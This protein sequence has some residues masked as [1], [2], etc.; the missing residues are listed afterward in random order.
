[1]EIKE[2]R[3]RQL[4]LHFLE[5]AK[6]KSNLIGFLIRVPLKKE[7][8][9]KV[10]V[11]SE[12][13]AEGAGAYAS[14]RE[15]AVAMEDCYGGIFDVSLLKKGEEQILFFYLEVV[16]C[17]EDLLEKAFVF[18][19]KIVEAPL[20][21]D[22][23][24]TEK[25]LQHS[26]EKVQKK[27]QRKKDDKKE[28]AK[29]RCLEELYEGKGFGVSG[30]GYEKDLDKINLEKLEK[31]CKKMYLESPMELL[32]LGEKDQLEDVKGYRKRFAIGGQTMCRRQ[33]EFV[34]FYIEK[35]E[36]CVEM[37]NVSQGRLSMAFQTGVSPKTNEFVTLL[38][39]NELLGGSSNSLLFQGL[40]EKQGL[41]YDISSYVYRFTGILMVQG[42]L[43]DKDYEKAKEEILTLLTD[44]TEEPVSKEKR[45]EAKKSL[46]RYFDSLQ[47]S[48][49]G[50][51]NFYLD[52]YLLGE[53][54]TIADWKK[55]I[56]QVSSR[57]IM[58]LA[59]QI[60][61]GLSYFLKRDGEKNEQK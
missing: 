56:R 9:T 45:V 14:T 4:Q 30:D 6:F 22:G 23:F 26:K 41:C 40:R 29:E 37:A 42:G 60:R 35:G 10:A 15:V 50:K 18:L 38:V 36:E 27:L 43:Q 19:Q 47:D 32:F 25:G 46:M 5:G 53:K 13:F 21:T 59:K 55:L 1:M 8:V 17:N 54:R 57:D 3:R 49:T 39:L 61:L 31:F 7:T 34:P 12:L 28:F 48:Q 52:G 44:L 20:V 58:T 24:F 2:E 33:K 51:I 11:L 16:K